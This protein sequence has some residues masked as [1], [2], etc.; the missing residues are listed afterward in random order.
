MRWRVGRGSPSA[1]ATPPPMV[2]A[3]LSDLVVAEGISSSSPASN[4]PVIVGG[5]DFFVVDSSGFFVSEAGGALVVSSGFGFSSSSSSSGFGSS[6]GLEGVVA[7]GA[8]LGFAVVE[9]GGAATLDSS[10]SPAAGLFPCAIAN[11]VKNPNRNKRIVECFALIMSS[12]SQDVYSENLPS[13]NPNKKLV[14]AW[15]SSLITDS[16]GVFLLVMSFVANKRFVRFEWFEISDPTESRS[17][18]AAI[19]I[20]TGD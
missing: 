17:S 20:R 7:G 10:S 16:P 1:A 14:N 5:S 11:T 18:I 12:S 6:V 9:G 13:L 2:A 19:L 8:G 15:A 3:G 4:P